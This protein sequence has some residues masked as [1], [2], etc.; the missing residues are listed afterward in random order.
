MYRHNDNRLDNLIVLPHSQKVQWVAVGH[1]HMHIFDK[2]EAEIYGMLIG[3]Q[4][5][6]R[7]F[8][9]KV[10]QFFNGHKALKKIAHPNN[11]LIISH[12]HTGKTNRDTSTIHYHFAFGNIPTMITEH[13]M[14]TIFAELWVK[15]CS[16]SSKSIW[17]QKANED[18]KAWLHYGHNE[19]RL[20]TKLGL[21]INATYIPE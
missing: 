5:T 12:L 3:A 21:D 13:D 6:G 4:K 1:T 7:L 2:T 16:Q 19:N 17:L 9:R 14:Q 11:P 18:N 20:G 15:K 8:A 10:A